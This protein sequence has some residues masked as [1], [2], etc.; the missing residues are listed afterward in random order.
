LPLPK[1]KGIADQVAGVGVGKDME[2]WKIALMGFAGAVCMAVFPIIWKA[3][4]KPAK[5]LLA[6]GG[7]G[8]MVLWLAAFLLGYPVA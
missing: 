7:I 3:S 2:F 6:I 8:L 4:W 1:Y 5:K